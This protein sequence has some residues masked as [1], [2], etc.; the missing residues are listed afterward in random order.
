MPPAPICGGEPRIS[1]PLDALAPAGGRGDKRRD[2]RWS[3]GGAGAATAVT[4]QAE[5]LAY[6]TLSNLDGVALSGGAPASGDA[7]A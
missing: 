4:A 1:A 2:T 6:R 5:A 3:P 7:A